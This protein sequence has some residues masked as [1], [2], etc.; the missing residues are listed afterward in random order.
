MK[1][2]GLCIKILFFGAMLTLVGVVYLVNTGN[3]FSFFSRLQ[4]P[5]PEIKGINVEFNQA[6]ARTF[7]DMHDSIEYFYY[8]E[9]AKDPKNNKVG[10]Y[11]YAENKDFIRAAAKMSN[12]NGGDWGYVLIPFNVK[13]RD[14]RKWRETFELLHDK[15][16]IPILKLYDV[17][18]ENYVEQTEK[19][20][21]FLDSFIWPI[22]QRYISVYNE[23]NDAKFWY[24]RV[25][26][27]EYVHI[28]NDTIDIFKEQNTNFYMMNGA[29][30]VSAGRL[31]GYMDSFDYMYAMNKEIPGIFE[32]IDGWA[33][34]AYP[35][36]N[37]S[38]S[39]YDYGRWSIRA[40]ESE[41]TYLKNSLGVKKDLPVFI[42]ET[43]WAHAEGSTYNPNFLTAAKGAEYIKIAFEEV[44]LPDDRV[45][46]VT[47]FTI[48]YDPPFD[49]FSWLTRD[50]VP[51][52][53]YDA[54]RSIKKIR[55]T[56][57]SLE[58]A[59]MIPDS[60]RDIIRE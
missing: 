9:P 47:P 17:D 58:K 8:K 30:N 40:Y 57:E 22:K 31:P 5:Q 7:C 51:Y 14:S 37:F 10:L 15:N 41:L 20:A 6:N 38:G 2:L 21:V 56:P 11:V 34:H 3:P 25:D 52:P 45:M 23:P 42:L 28:L 12:S 27:V 50:R 43:G 33:S 54:V 4:E 36:P 39:P 48:W 29:F 60:C 26:P 55:G 35:Q 1:K 53:Q 59:V 46:A 13:D 16:L 44:W 24:G 19:A 32:K 18:P 49:H